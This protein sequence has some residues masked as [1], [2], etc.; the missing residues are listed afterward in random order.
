MTDFAPVEKAQSF[1][2]PSTAN[3][4]VD[5]FDNN[6]LS[7]QPVNASMLQVYDFTIQRPTSI[8]N[9]FFTRIGVS[10]V[11]LEW[12]IPNIHGSYGTSEDA[13]P[14]NTM[15]FEASGVALTT[16][17][18]AEGNYTAAGL[19]NAVATTLTNLCSG[20]APAITWTVAITTV[21]IGGAGVATSTRSSPCLIPSGAIQDVIFGGPIADLL[22]L[23]RLIATNWSTAVPIPI[24]SYDVDLR[25]YRYLDFVSPTLTYTQ[26]LKDS[27]TAP[28]VRDVLCRWYMDFDDSVEYDTYG[29]P[30]LMGYLPFRIRRLFSP[31][32]Q[33]RWEPN[34]PLGN[35]T[36]QVYGDDGQL[37]T[38]MNKV[39]LGSIPGANWLMTLQV[40]E[41]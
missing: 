33:I 2:Q 32:K 40:S 17:T 28:Q 35:L 10:E 26:A 13:S 24:N 1:R 12:S 11:V 30:I 9:G 31:P 22:N 18:F 39:L 37:A 16:V 27:S 23:P 21:V 4:M 5:S 15:T 14:N 3:L 29:F 7:G 6:T 20:L 36:F 34:L 25:P 38:L 8:L 19:L 41:V